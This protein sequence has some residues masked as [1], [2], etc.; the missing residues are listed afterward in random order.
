MKEKLVN[1]VTEC[2]RCGR[3]PDLINKTFIVLIPK[4]DK[5]CNFN[6]FR[7]I[8]L[9]NFAYKLV[10]KIVANRLSGVID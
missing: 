3:M 5:A 9:C 4:T 8:S 7:L 6:H 2:F 10:A 1:Y